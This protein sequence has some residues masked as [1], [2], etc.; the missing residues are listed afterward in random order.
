VIHTLGTKGERKSK[1]ARYGQVRDHEY[2][3]ILSLDTFLGF[4]AN[5]SEAAEL[6][7]RKSKQLVAEWR[8]K[9]GSPQMVGKRRPN[10]VTY[11]LAEYQ[12]RSSRGKD[13]RSVYTIQLSTYHFT[14]NHQQDLNPEIRLGDVKVG[15][16][17][18]L[19]DTRLHLVLSLQ[20]F[21]KL[22]STTNANGPDESNNS[23][24]L[25]YDSYGYACSLPHVL[26]LLRSKDFKRYVGEV[27][28]AAA[29]ASRESPR[30][31]EKRPHSADGELSLSD[32]AE[33]APAP[34]TA[35]EVATE[36]DQ[37]PDDEDDETADY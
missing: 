14:F 21:I 11:N 10:S 3:A 24:G 9:N 5:P 16:T 1:G 26:G 2:I 18:R 29:A 37:Y 33:Q 4:F 19:P 6:L 27:R 15:G 36:P 8:E 13:E 17:A 30:T 25:S 31:G 7:L 28:E 23:E 20:F 35:E 22:K 32:L 34:T 12:W